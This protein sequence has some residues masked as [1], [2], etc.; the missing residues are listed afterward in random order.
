MLFAN[1]LKPGTPVVV[2][3]RAYMVESTSVG[4]TAQRRRTFHVRL[5][6]IL[7]GQNVEKSFGETDRFEEPELKRRDVQL[8]YKKGREWVFMDQE[9]YQEYAL[10]EETL[11][12]AKHFL[13]EGEAYR[14]LLLDGRPTGLELPSAF[15]LEVVETAAPTHAAQ[16]SSAAKEAKLEGGLTVR[17]P[18]F[19][20]VG[21]KIRI[22]TDTLEYLGKA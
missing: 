13:R 11:G 15:V 2:E 10:S 8:S 3:G 19:I 7:T 1:Q 14:I 5:R 18:P 9:D 4:G 21:E 16:G 12:R 17:V 6:D 20:K 22:S